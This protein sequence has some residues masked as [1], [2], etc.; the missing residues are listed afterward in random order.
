MVPY[1]LWETLF[2]RPV[3]L[4]AFAETVDYEFLDESYAL[5]FAALNRGMRGEEP[6]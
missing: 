6:G 3:D 4:T 1:F 2:P 5:E